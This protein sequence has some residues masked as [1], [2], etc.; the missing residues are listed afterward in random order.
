[1]FVF[2][3]FLGLRLFHCQAKAGSFRKQGLRHRAAT[4]GQSFS[5]LSAFH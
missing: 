5:P 3:Q 1:M 2:I 4:H